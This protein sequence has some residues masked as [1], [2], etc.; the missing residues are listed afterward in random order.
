MN[1]PSCFMHRPTVWSGYSTWWFRI[2][3]SFHLLALSASTCDFYRHCTHFHQDLE[4]RKAKETSERLH[5]ASPGNGYI[6]PTHIPC[7]H[8]STC[9]VRLVWKVVKFWAQREETGVWTVPWNLPK[10]SDHARIILETCAT[11]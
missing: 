10:H 5:W 6:F 1:V 8:L 2:P 4:R 11:N 9:A 7:Q 3:G